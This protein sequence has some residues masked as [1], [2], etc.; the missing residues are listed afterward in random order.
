MSQKIVCPN[1]NTKID[2]DKLG[3]EKYKNMLEKQ[4]KELKAEMNEK[5]LKWAEEK[6]KKLLEEK[7]KKDYI[8]MED[9]K[10]RLKEQEKS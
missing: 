7:S 8:E 2:L 5:A 10:N 9:L 6:A 3:E 1:C 4:E